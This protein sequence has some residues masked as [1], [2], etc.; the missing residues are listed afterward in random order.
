MKEMTSTSNI[1]ISTFYYSFFQIQARVFE[2]AFSFVCA[3]VDIAVVKVCV[4]V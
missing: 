2:S 4:Y 1:C 3:Y